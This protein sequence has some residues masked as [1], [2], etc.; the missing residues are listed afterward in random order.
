M[1][2]AEIF[3]SP[4]ELTE[5]AARLFAARAAEAVSARGRFAVAL[6][7][8]RQRADDDYDDIIIDDDDE[9]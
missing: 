9:E 4:M 6:M 3:P 1:T 7:T 5:S 8:C 2:P